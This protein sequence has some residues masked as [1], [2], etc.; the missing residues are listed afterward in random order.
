AQLTFRPTPGTSL[1]LGLDQYHRFDRDDTQITI[2]GVQRLPR[3]FTLAGSVTL[4]PD[5]AVVARQV[6]DV[7][8][9]SEVVK[10]VTALLRYRHMTYAGDVGVDLVSPGLELT[11]PGR[12]S[13]L[14]RYCFADSSASGV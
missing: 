4:A 6:Y 10:G 12:V 9:T 13:L 3:G 2:G 11:W 5:A 14:A 8:A 1:F 7:E